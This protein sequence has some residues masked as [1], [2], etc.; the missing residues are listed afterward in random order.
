MWFDYSVKNKKIIYHATKCKKV[1][2]IYVIYLP[3]DFYL[4]FF[5]LLV[6][7]KYMLIFLDHFCYFFS[8]TVLYF[9][10]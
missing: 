2:C 6:M 8:V 1:F 7:F 5:A 4:F 9:D 3:Y 10:N